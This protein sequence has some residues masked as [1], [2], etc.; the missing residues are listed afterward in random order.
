MEQF[1]AVAVR[2]TTLF[3]NVDSNASALSELRKRTPPCVP[4]S[5]DTPNGLFSSKAAA[6]AVLCVVMFNTRATSQPADFAAPSCLFYPD[7]QHDD[8]WTHDGF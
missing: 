7:M 6:A 2:D 3:R 5:S 8:G 4:R 1:A